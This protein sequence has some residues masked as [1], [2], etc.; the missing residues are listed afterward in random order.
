MKHALTNVKRVLQYGAINEVSIKKPP[1][2]AKFERG[3]LGRRRWISEDNI[4]IDSTVG[5]P[6][7]SPEPQNIW[8]LPHVTL[9]T[10]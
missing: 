5:P 4:K 8:A 10:G 3:D 7:G 2:N 6:S 9:R 1:I